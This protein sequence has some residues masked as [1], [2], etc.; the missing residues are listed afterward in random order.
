M[1]VVRSHAPTPFGHQGM[2]VDGGQRSRSLRVGNPTLCRLSYAH[3]RGGGGDRTHTPARVSRFSRPNSA[4]A[5]RPS[6]V[7]G[8]GFEPAPAAYETAEVPIPL[9]RIASGGGR[10]RTDCGNTLQK[11]PAPLALTPVGGTGWTRT[12]TALRPYPRSRRAPC[13]F[14]HRS[15]IG[16][17]GFEPRPR[18]S[19]PRVLPITPGTSS[20]PAWSRTRSLGVQSAARYRLRHGPVMLATPDCQIAT[21]RGERWGSNPQSPAPQAGALPVELRSPRKKPAVSGGWSSLRSS[22]PPAQIMMSHSSLPTN[23]FL[24]GLRPARIASVG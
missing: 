5:V 16:P 2:R 14:G 23:V 7:A 1:N 6:V 9:P 12:T 20:R 11:C 22:L 3:A 17:R 15:A 8:T 4:P 24:S 21:A 19:E 18:G 10:N 13:R